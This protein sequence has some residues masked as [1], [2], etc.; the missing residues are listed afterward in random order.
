MSAVE[1]KKQERTKA[2]QQVT[3]ASRRLTRAVDR[4]VDIDILTVLMVE[5][6][7]AFDDFCII[8][9]EYEILVS[10]EEHAEHEIV[11]GLDLTAYRANVSE[12]YT[13]A[14]NAFVQAKA[15]KTTSVAQL[16]LVPPSANPPTQDGNTTPSEQGPVQTAASSSLSQTPVGGTVSS[17]SSQN[18]SVAASVSN[19]QATDFHGGEGPFIPSQPPF[20]Q[21]TATH[22]YPG[23]TMNVFPY[24][25]VSYAM[26][27]QAN[28]LLTG[29]GPISHTG[30]SMPPSQH[31]F[32]PMPSFQQSIGGQPYPT[33]Q[34]NPSPHHLSNSGVA[35]QSE[36]AV[37]TG[38]H[39]KK[40]TLPIFSGQR[41]DWPEFKTVWKQ[42]AEGA[43]K[44]KTA[45]AHEL[46]RSVKGEASQRIKSV[47]VT[48]PEA[49]DTM[50]KK[51]EDYY[52]D[53][54]ATVQAALE[55]LHKLKPVSE[56][57]YR[58]LV[59]FV[60]VVESSYS[61]LEELDQLNTLTMR[62][63]DY[64]NALLPNHLR[65]E[66]IRKYH[67]MSQIEKLQP[68]KPFMKFLE[69]EREAVARL[70]EYQPRRRRTFE[71]LKNGDRGKG[72]TH[73]GTG[74]SQGQKQFYQCAFH[75]RDTVKHKTSDCKEF[76]KLPIS[77]EGGKFELLKQVNACFVCFG[78]HPQQKCP[79]KNHVHCVE[80]R[81]TTFS[82][83]SQ[84]KR[85]K[86]Q[87]LPVRIRLYQ[88]LERKK[89]DKLTIVLMLNRQV[90]LQ[91]ELALLSIPSS[92]QRCVRVG[93]MLPYSVMV[94]QTQPT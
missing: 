46:K 2:K 21:P 60:D 71:V 85:K 89:I 92:R 6:E 30:Y 76:Q 82:C 10:D 3:T 94:A 54:S 18:D 70:A 67:D 31:Y 87:T 8:D 57:D 48:K 65:I 69:R 37:A 20:H 88:H 61:Q 81:S 42:F 63:V 14:R 19:V 45:L 7:K 40:M 17:V 47:Y 28:N 36:G 11:N 4:G 78:N 75:K 83:A 66:W 59:E 1:E 50:W 22:V 51:L 15:A 41:K 58:G 84:G 90:M 29:L 9:E 26:P 86:V 34:V 55:D 38:V 77:G 13:G 72:L 25:P 32:V 91:E 27:T 53:T 5:L 43:Y 73:H 93:R 62:D 39:L 56:T 64:V 68:F 44:N 33:Q 79:S 16:D 24:Q 12:V 80:V 52:D 23:H 74:T 35:D 49:Y